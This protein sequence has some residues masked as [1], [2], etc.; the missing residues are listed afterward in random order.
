MTPVKRAAVGRKKFMCLP[1]SLFVV[2]CV[3]ATLVAL[4]YVGRLFLRE[5]PIT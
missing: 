1:F 3:L 4:R 5:A 2:E